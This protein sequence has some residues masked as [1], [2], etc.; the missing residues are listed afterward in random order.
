MFI[1]NIFFFKLLGLFLLEAKRS[2]IGYM[3]L[4]VGKYL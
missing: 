3:D 4:S 1:D 2:N